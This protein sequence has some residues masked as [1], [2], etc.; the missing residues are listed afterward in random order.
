VARVFLCRI[1]FEFVSVDCFFRS[2]KNTGHEMP[3]IVKTD[4]HEMPEIVKTDSI[5]GCDKP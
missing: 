3:E 2:A 5:C 1:S 4:G